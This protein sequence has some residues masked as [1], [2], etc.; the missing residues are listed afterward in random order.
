MGT[1]GSREAKSEILEALS[2]LDRLKVA[3]WYYRNKGAD[4]FANGLRHAQDLIA[5][6]GWKHLAPI[7]VNLYGGDRR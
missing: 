1:E 3:E 6:D 2:L 7:W 5:E 4:D